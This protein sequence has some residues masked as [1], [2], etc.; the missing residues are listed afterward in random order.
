MTEKPEQPSQLL[1]TQRIRN[2]IIEY[3]EVA[4]DFAAQLEY[5]KNVPIAHV[6]SEVICEWNDWVN[7][8]SQPTFTEPVFTVE[9]R[10][11][12]DQFHTIWDKVA[13]ETP[14]PLPELEVLMKSEPW[15]RL[16]D[17]ASR[18][19]QVFEQRGRFSED[20]EQF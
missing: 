10:A 4:S 17:A 3:L 12:I 11:A 7:E 2:R 8:Q 16:R 18:A 20:F 6:P 15:R 9:E 14:D 1:I 5:Q 19:L 13:D